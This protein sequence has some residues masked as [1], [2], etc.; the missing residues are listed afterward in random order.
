M[1]KVEE[2]DSNGDNLWAASMQDVSG[3]YSWLPNTLD[4]AED[5]II[6][7]GGGQ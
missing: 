2:E 4:P 5:I 1:E 3:A 7:F 6:D